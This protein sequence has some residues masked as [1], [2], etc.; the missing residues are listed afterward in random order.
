MDVQKHMAGQPPG[1]RVTEPT[2]HRL[3]AGL[4]R[5]V[6][7]GLTGSLGA[8][9]STALRM[10]AELGAAV[11]SADETVHELYR[12]ADV[13][14]AL[15]DHFGAVVFGDDGSVDRTALRKVVL[16]DGQSLRWLEKFIHARVEDEMRRRAA[17]CSVGTVMV[18]EVPLLF[19]TSMEG[20]FDLTVAIEAELDL[21]AQRATEPGRL[22]MLEGF[23]RKQLTSEERMARAD[24]SFVNDGEYE[25]LR[26]FIEG[27]YRRAVASAGNVVVTDEKRVGSEG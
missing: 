22:A 14:S 3:S 21:R 15:R 27:V 24:M 8:G 26:I 17:G 23:D 11:F 7:V 16:A 10:F 20:M 19:D 1:T 18:F 13:C 5:V 2:D 4:D 9:K 12:R 25:H 6:A